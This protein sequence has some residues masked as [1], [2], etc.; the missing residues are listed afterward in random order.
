[1]RLRAV[2]RASGAV[3]SNTTQCNPSSRPA[4]LCCVVHLTARVVSFLT[5]GSHAWHNMQLDCAVDGTF[6]S[7]IE[8]QRRYLA[9]ILGSKP[10]NVSRF[11][12]TRSGQ[13]Q[14]LLCCSSSS[15]LRASQLIGLVLSR[16]RHAQGKGDRRSLF[17]KYVPYGMHCECAPPRTHALTHSRTH[18]LT[19]L[20]PDA[21]THSRTRRRLSLRLSV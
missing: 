4:P 3:S 20:H 17:V 2:Y 18:A 7:F 12:K 9:L 5:R 15:S 1:M 16:M 11:A 13:E 19:Y 10:K 8:R 6:Y 14:Q 21:L